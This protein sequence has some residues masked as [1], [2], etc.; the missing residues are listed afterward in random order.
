MSGAN[1]HQHIRPARVGW[2]GLHREGVELKALAT[3][4]ILSARKL[5]NLVGSLQAQSANPR[6][7]DAVTKGWKW[8]RSKDKLEAV[9]KELQNYKSVLDKRLLV[10]LR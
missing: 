7:R 3:K 5:E 1:A 9:T 2:M 4:T 6:V 8:W 10:D